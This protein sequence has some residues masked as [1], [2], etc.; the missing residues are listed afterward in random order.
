MYKGNDPRRNSSGYL[1]P[2]AFAAMKSISREERE[3]QRVDKLLALIFKICRK[4]GF[5]VVNRIVLKDMTTG[6]EWR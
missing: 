5:Q 6:K 4:A 1:D 3:K 2:T